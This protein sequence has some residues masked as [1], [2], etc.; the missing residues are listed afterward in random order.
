MPMSC[1]RIVI[2]GAGPVGLCLAL[3]LAQQ[4]VPVTVIEALGDDNFLEQV[5][6]AGTN[7]PATLE[8]YD[9]IGLYAKL[10]PRGIV[11]PCSTTGTAPTTR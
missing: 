6:R 1:E 11:A 7:H 9:R 4:G 5:P 10:E 2:I 3:A 8:M